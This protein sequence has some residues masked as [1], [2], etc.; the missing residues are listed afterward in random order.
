MKE[1]GNVA[2]Y[3][4][5]GS[6]RGLGCHPFSPDIFHHC[7]LHLNLTL[8]SV[9]PQPTCLASSLILPSLLKIGAKLPQP[10]PVSAASV[11]LP[12]PFHPSGG[13][14]LFAFTVSCFEFAPRGLTRI[15]LLS[16]DRPV[17]PIQ[18]AACSG[19]AS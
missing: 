1:V 3:W 10:Q 12:G 2:V 4:F 19:D 11:P 8:S 5:T 17:M 13:H 18:K 15:E 16:H 9:E 6:H 7:L 14:L